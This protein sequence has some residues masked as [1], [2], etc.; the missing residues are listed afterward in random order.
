MRREE[1]LARH[2]RSW[3]RFE[4]L[5]TLLEG[6]R[7][8]GRLQGIALAERAP[9][10]REFDAHY[11][12]ICRHLA[13]ARQR[14]YGD[15]L[16]GNLNDLALR[17]Y[18]Q[19]YSA[20]R[21]FGASLRIL[22]LAEIP[23]AI[24]GSWRAVALSAAAFLLPLA[25]MAFGVF[26]EPSL[27]RTM[28]SAEDLR[29][30]EKMYDPS[31]DHYARERESDTDLAMFGFYVY[32]NIGLAFQTFAW[33]ILGTVGS[34][35]ILVYNGLVIGATMG[36]LLRV[37]YGDTFLPFV[38]GHAAFE[39][40]AIVLAGAAG[41]ELGWSW[42]APGRLSRADSLRRA[43]RRGAYL[44]A[45]AFILLSLA[46]FVEAY[47]SSKITIAPVWKYAVGSSLWVLLL[48]WIVKVPRR[49]A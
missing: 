21:G 10:A 43:G 2:A 35:F 29:T 28:L 46:A 40:F 15:D 32:N 31:S 9:E 11:R 22:L 1:F 30:Y 33:G 17:A 49:G 47:W 34:L 44:V 13:L 14:D 24:R 37:G 36:H 19:L 48:L 25:A 38:A 20:R 7:S 18:R 41:L 5:V 4:M 23:A 8:R 16:T 42:I 12:M 39:L 27:G 3:Y 26:D 6:R 45:G